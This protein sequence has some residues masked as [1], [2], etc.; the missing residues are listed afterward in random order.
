MQ[1][2]DLFDSYAKDY[3]NNFI[4]NP[5]AEYQ[6]SIVH[7]IIRPC[8]SPQKKVLDVGCGPGA[9]FDFYKSL[10][11]NIDA[12]D[13]SREMVKA[14]R[15][16]AKRLGLNVRIARSAIVD[17]VP[18]IKYDIVI[19]N[20]G[21]VNAIDNL[22]E[23]L[24]TLSRIMAKD[25]LLF[26]VSMPPV[27]IFSFKA[28]FLFFRFFKLYNR[29]FQHKAITQEGFIFKYY[30]FRDFKNYFRLEQ[31]NNLCSILPS[32]Q[33][34]ANSSFAQ[35]WTKLFIKLDKKLCGVI[36]SFFGAD[37]IVYKM[38]VKSLENNN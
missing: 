4:K 31:R 20:F 3:Q 33:Q 34:F 29:L 25:G 30:T 6:R 11:L 21:V 22:E 12:I 9:D 2:T 7:E 37:H 28:D 19:M 23:S 8:L 26:I 5:L 15:Q 17:F 36:P 16:Q 10:S 24:K 38:S 27:H 13:I 14:A 35:K 1:P 18:D 32:P